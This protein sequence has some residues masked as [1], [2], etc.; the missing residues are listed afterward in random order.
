MTEIKVFAI[1]LNGKTPDYVKNFTNSGFSEYVANVSLL[2]VDSPVVNDL[3][4][5]LD[6]GNCNFMNV[7]K[8]FCRLQ[9]VCLPRHVRYS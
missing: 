9:K 3:L 8:F 2:S 4:T 5:T 1:G 6:N 7:L